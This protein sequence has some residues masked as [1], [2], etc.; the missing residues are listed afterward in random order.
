MLARTGSR[1]NAGKAAERLTSGK[2]MPPG[3]VPA[4]EKKRRKKKNGEGLRAIL[5]RESS[6]R[7]DRLLVLAGSRGE[8]AAHN[9]TEHQ[10]TGAEQEIGTGLRCWADIVEQNV[11]TACGDIEKRKAA[12]IHGYAARPATIVRAEHGGAE[13]AVAAGPEELKSLIAL[14]TFD[15]SEGSPGKSGDLDKV[16]SVDLTVAVAENAEAEFVDSFVLA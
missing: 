6:S 9:E 13:H 16:V 2:T 7:F 14:N 11:S 10:Q 5:P 8:L 15:N 12:Q 1:F 3:S 4:L